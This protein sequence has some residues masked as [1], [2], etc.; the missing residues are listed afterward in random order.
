[1]KDKYIIIAILIL[2]VI[3]FLYRKQENITSTDS[4]KTLSDEAVQ[5]IASV[6]NTKNL[7]V[8]KLT[9]PKIS[10]PNGKYYLAVQDDGNLVLYDNSGNA[11]WDSV[12]AKNMQNKYEAGKLP[13]ANGQFVAIM[14]NDTNFV[15]YNNG[16]K[17]LWDSVNATNVQNMYNGGNGPC[18]SI[19]TPDRRFNLSFDYPQTDKMHL[20]TH[21]PDGSY[22][23]L[24]SYNW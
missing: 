15:V 20:A 12:S 6:Y 9:T 23:I 11:K 16:G 10:S 13:S 22:Q 19:V 14:Q 17:P 1:M 21:R 7:T 2:I 5:N 18:G 4:G 8:D 24:D 3:L